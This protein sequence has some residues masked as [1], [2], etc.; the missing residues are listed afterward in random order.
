M[1]M[2]HDI[3]DENNLLIK[4]FSNMVTTSNSIE[5]CKNPQINWRKKKTLN[6]KFLNKE[7]NKSYDINTKTKK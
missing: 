4:Y 6:Y 3:N 7:T 5:T 1:S 2:H